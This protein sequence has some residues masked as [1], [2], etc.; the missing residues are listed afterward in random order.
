MLKFVILTI[1]LLSLNL[2]ASTHG[3]GVMAPTN[4]E[5]KSLPEGG[6]VGTIKPEI[7]QIIRA[8]TGGGGVLGRPEIVYNIGKKDG[9]VKFG[10]GQLVDQK[11][12]V[13]N[14]EMPETELFKDEAVV[15][16]LEASKTLSD[17]AEIK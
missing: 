16:A 6:S 9:I 1:S 2:F 7:G 10:Y 11:W 14:I 15:K 13:Q 17:W 5:R 12:Q 4:S 3:G 8:G